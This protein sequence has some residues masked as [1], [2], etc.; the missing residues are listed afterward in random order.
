MRV[1][2][3]IS[4]REVAFPDGE[5]LVSRTDPAGRIV[6]VNQAFIGLSGYTEAELIGQP[7]NLIRHPHMPKEAFADLWATVKA[8]RPWEGIVKN[9]TKTGDYYWVRANVTPVIED[10]QLTGYISIRSKPSRAQVD[11]SE[12]AYARVRAGDPS[13]RVSEGEAVSTA[14]SHRFGVFAA[15][16]TGRLT[17]L[18]CGLTLLVALVG[19]LGLAGMSDTNAALLSVFEDRTVPAG[20]MGDIIDRMRDNL[21]QTTLLVIDLRDGAEDRIVNGRI[22]QIEAN[23]AAI[24][25]T[26]RRYMSGRLTPE[27]AVLAQ[28]FGDMRGAFVKEGL[29]PAIEMARASDPL[30]IETHYRTKIAPLFAAAHAANRELLQMQ[31]KVA[32]ETFTEAKNDFRFHL[33]LMTV[34]VAVGA[35]TTILGGRLL[36]E[37]VRR[38]LTRFESHFDAIARADFGHEIESPAATEFRR[39]T[40]LL[41]AMKA[42]LAYG[43]QER[44]ENERKA[45]EERARALEEMAVTV[46]R[47]AGGAVEQVAG[48]TG[49]MAVDAE[50]M[51]RSAER[52]S[53]HSQGVAAAAEEALCNAQAVAGAAEEMAASIQEIASQVAYA[54]QVTRASVEDSDRTQDTIQSLADE[55]AKIGAIATL[56]SNIAGQTN[57]LALNATIEAARAGE[58]GKGFAVVANEV[59]NLATQT[60]HS[61]SE[62][63]A[64]IAKIQDLTHEVVDAVG[65]I[66]SNIRR[67]D[68]VASSIAAA[69]EEQSAAT[70]EISRNVIETSSAAQEVSSLIASV[71]RDAAETGVQ[72][73]AVRQISSEVASSIHELRQVLV[74][75]VRTSTKEA[76]RRI[77]QRINL[78]SRCAVTL[79]GATTS[80]ELEDISAGGAAIIDGPQA[81]EGQQGSLEVQGNTL[82]FTVRSWQEGMLRVVFTDSPDRC[83]RVVESLT[84]RP[85]SCRA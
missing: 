20:E 27:E 50:A 23:I 12:A 17:A 83:Q 66:G 56:I 74:R 22:N 85:V 31:I 77:C 58:A 78:H 45:N 10:G 16:I 36:L 75:V 57:L 33:I 61:T 8:G 37:A 54:G 53:E 2:E 5:V 7:H 11:A 49:E 32:D 72:A 43:I 84:G 79:G 4:D 60:A 15:S 46:E 19:G 64:Q 25:E 65:G 41:R 44:S 40:M 13:L 55:V 81:G 73:S 68:E 6:F 35:V 62:I 42:K 14:L 18:F 76:D 28:R 3:P 69:M 38:P 24:S 63:N 51:A 47:E 21:Q 30:R 67:I 29:L 82:A 26:W 52:V 34:I 1:N 9:R 48:R 59:K 80:A 39:L 71:S 70:S